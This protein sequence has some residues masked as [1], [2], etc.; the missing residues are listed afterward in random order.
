MDTDHTKLATIDVS[1]NDYTHPNHTGDVTSVGDGVT[2]IADGVIVNADVSSN[3][4]I[5][6][7]KLADGT[8][9]DTEFQYIV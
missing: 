9:T 8:V 3:A 2:A 4:A 5:D 6:V 1:A 7:T